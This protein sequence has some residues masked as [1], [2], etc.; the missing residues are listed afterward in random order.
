MTAL[1]IGHAFAGMPRPLHILLA[2]LG[3]IVAGGIWA[4]SQAF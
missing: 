2:S 4:G 1:W 3:A